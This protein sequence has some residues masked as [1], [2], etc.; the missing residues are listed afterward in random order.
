MYIT[1]VFITKTFLINLLCILQLSLLRRFFDHIQDVK[2][3]IF[4]TYNGDMFDWYV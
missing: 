4:V 2:P 1:G 3:H